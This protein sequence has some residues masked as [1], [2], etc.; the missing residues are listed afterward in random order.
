[1][2]IREQGYIWIYFVSKLST[3]IGR[4]FQARCGFSVCLWKLSAAEATT[5][6]HA[7]SSALCNHLAYEHQLLMPMCKSLKHHQFM[8]CIV[9]LQ[10]NV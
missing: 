8:K 2:K 10:F 1:M 7:G 4:S 9:T 5:C 6:T 3:G